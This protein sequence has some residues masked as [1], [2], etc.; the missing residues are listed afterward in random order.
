MARFLYLDPNPYYPSSLR[1]GGRLVVTPS[2]GAARALGVAH[3]SLRHLAQS[4]LQAE[5]LGV[6]TPLGVD[7][8]LKK[9]LTQVLGPQD[10]EGLSRAWRPVVQELLGAGLPE[11]LAPVSPRCE[12]LIQVALTYRCLLRGENLVDPQE[13]LLQAAG[14]PLVSRPLLVYGY[15]PPQ[16]QERHFIDR[17][18][19]PGSCLVV[20]SGADVTWYQ[21]QGW[22]VQEG[23]TP[24]Q[25]LGEH[26]AAQL[27]G[28]AS[29]LFPGARAYSY[30]R[31]S[32]EIRGVLG[33][34]KELLQGGASPGSI[35]LVTTQPALYG[36]GV[37]A[38]AREYGVPV[39][40]GYTLPLRATNLG[41]WLELLLGVEENPGALTRLLGHP[42]SGDWGASLGEGLAP[43][44]RASSRDW[45]AWLEQVWAHFAIDYSPDPQV[46]LGTQGLAAGLGE[47]ARRAGEEQLSR[48]EFSRL[49][50][51][52]VVAAQPGRGGVE[53]L[54]PQTLSGARYPHVF[55]LGAQADLLPKSLVDNPVLDFVDRQAL[56]ARGLNLPGAATLAEQQAQEFDNLLQACTHSLTCSYVGLPSPYL[57]QLG[58]G[59]QTPPDPA[60]YSQPEWRQRS[61]GPDSPDP[62][63][64]QAWH[65]WQVESRREGAYPPDE[66]DGIVGI[67]FP[68]QN[69]WFSVSQL[70]SLG[71]CPFRWFG[72]QILR[73]KAPPE[74][75]LTPLKKGQLYHEV[76]HQLV[77]QSCLH[78]AQRQ[79]PQFLARVFA[80]VEKDLELPALPTWGVQRQEHLETLTRVLPML[81]P[82]E[83]Q[84]LKTEA[85]F[86]GTWQGFRI[87]GKVDRI[88][89]QAGGLVLIDYKTGPSLPTGVKNSAGK[90]IVDLQLL[91]Y[92][93]V[94]APQLRPGQPLLNK[95]YFSLT[96]GEPLTPKDPS[97]GEIEEI[98]QGWHDYLRRG[99]YPVQ[100]D[101]DG[102]ACRFCTLDLVCRR[103]PRLDLK[104]AS[105]PPCT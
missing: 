31:Q 78:P 14:C 22:E 36:P 100:P 47:L 18:A 17:L 61:L 80:Q 63:L 37:A 86:E 29:D 68:T 70:T 73:L 49:L 15:F 85:W 76:L 104:L 99:E 83:R 66:Y 62:I 71:Q 21:E 3:C 30:D 11:G 51:L 26:L 45:G 77:S 32:A 88:D 48:R 40:L 38:V 1:R 33:Q 101:L 67:P 84:V 56:V 19:A 39:D 10:R 44:T 6:A 54:V 12:Q 57:V 41:A 27:R 102:E 82:P 87:R 9:A 98:T 4:A 81:F 25:S 91:V 95:F 75:D 96:K 58:L 105:S 69:H 28:A 93:Q 55:L 92:A 72:E 34:V 16:P 23:S 64:G 59:G 42:L 97:P 35:A 74:K 103:G 43:P 65:S 89:K 90:A 2:R 79:E 20:N 24:A 60:A 5:G 13:V 8:A 50:D 53:L 52:V 46:A 94:A 7:W